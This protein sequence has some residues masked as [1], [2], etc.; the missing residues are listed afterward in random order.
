MLIVM[1]LMLAIGLQSSPAIFAAALSAP[2][3]CQSASEMS[4]QK[5]CCPSGIYVASCC[6]DACMMAA[7][8]SLGAIPMI[9]NGHS[10]FDP[11]FVV[12]TFNTRG[13]APL[14]RPPIL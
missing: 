3:E 13:D 5:S 7:S 1:G 6:L 8:I 2:S 9:W 11:Q 10:T 4:A 12:S 14:I